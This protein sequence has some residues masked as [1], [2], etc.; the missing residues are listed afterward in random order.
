MYDIIGQCSIRSGSAAFGRL[1]CGSGLAATLLLLC[2]SQPAFAE[3][4][5]PDSLRL[6]DQNHP[7][8][9]RALFACPCLLE[10]LISKVQLLVEIQWSVGVTIVVACISMLFQGRI[11][12]YKA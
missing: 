6:G 12:C 11:G 9:A 4:L 5:A 2:R 3:T 8:A 10:T 7:G 1:R